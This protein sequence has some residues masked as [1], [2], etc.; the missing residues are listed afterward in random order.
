[1]QYIYEIRNTVRKG[2][3]INCNII[4]ND[5]RRATRKMGLVLRL[6]D[7]FKGHTYRL[8]GVSD[9]GG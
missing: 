5:R 6:A 8:L 3:I 1:M 4:E 7:G 9:Y 2:R